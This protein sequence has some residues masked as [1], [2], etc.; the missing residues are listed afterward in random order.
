MA[1]DSSTGNRADDY[2]RGVPVDQTAA[3][4]PSFDWR[5]YLLALKQR[6]WLI[7]LCA[8]A[9]VAT[10]AYQVNKAVPIYASR[11]VLLLEPQ[12]DRILNF[13]SVKSDTIADGASFQTM[14]ETLT[15]RTMMERVAARLKLDR[16]FVFM[17]KPE[18]REAN[19][20]ESVTG[21]LRGSIR[22]VRRGDTR[23]IDIV[24]EHTDPETARKIADEVASD[25]IRFRFEAKSQSN[26]MANQFLLEEAN[27][28]KEKINR[29]EVALHEFREKKGLVSLERGQDVVISRFMELNGQFNAARD[30]RAQLEADMAAASR[31]GIDPEQL[32]KLPSIAQQPAVAGLLSSIADKEAEFAALKQRYLPKHPKFAMAATQVENLKARLPEAALAAASTL[33]TTFQGVKETEERLGRELQGQ[34]KDTYTLGKMQVEYDSLKREIETDKT[35][36]SGVLA[37][38]KETDLTQSL[39]Q[40]T[41]KVVERA[42]A[43]YVPV[44]P[45]KQKMLAQWSLG[46]LALGLML[47]IG[48]HLMDSSIKT[49]GD[50]E[51]TLQLP[52]LTAVT[53]RK[54]TAKKHSKPDLET[55]HHKHSPVSE[56]FRTL[57]SALILLGKSDERRIILFTSA[58]PAE[59]KSFCA[60]NYA[61]TLA[62]QGLKTVLV[63][64]DL[65]KPVVAEIFMDKAPHLGV[66]DLLAGQCELDEVVRA[67]PVDCLDVLPAGSLPP[68][69]SELLSGRDFGDLLAV[70]AK[71]YERVV[72]DSPPVL[73]VSDPL[74][75]APHTDRICLVVR[76]HKT[77]RHSAIRACAAIAKTGKIPSGI[78]LNRLPISAVGYYYYYGSRYG[79]KQVYGAPA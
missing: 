42:V 49:V 74:V 7:I 73:A 28:L 59:G 3:M 40:S 32:L 39:E 43:S 12:E 20:M 35:V 13:Q 23:L 4:G 18:G 52:V 26:Q 2:D 46:G 47:A 70:L 61:V 22:A 53:V 64:C 78:V 58:V 31:A 11:S 8:V 55:V 77:A 50:A 79:Q 19:A 34:E 67:T 75:I 68:N 6:L 30:N 72:I 16:D 44:R 1:R 36:F 63:D 57:R 29:A 14:L 65:R 25:F 15:S 69:P 33:A 27:R 66:A 9:G 51:R 21:A 54:T 41:V 71:R 37:R 45:D 62:N 38:L 24:A 5:E 48:L 17:P 60:A 76:S 56:A 10:A